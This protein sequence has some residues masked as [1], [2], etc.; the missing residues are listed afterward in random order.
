MPVLTCDHHNTGFTAIN[1]Q[2]VSSARDKHLLLSSSCEA[3]RCIDMQK[4]QPVVTLL[5]LSMSA[6]LF[7]FWPALT[8]ICLPQCMFWKE[9]E[10]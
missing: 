6:A 8:L 10:N 3:P 7:C 2:F 5:L 9:A 4:M 1:T